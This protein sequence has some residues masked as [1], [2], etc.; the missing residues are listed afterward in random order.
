LG[1]AAVREGKTS[2]G[3]R[4]EAAGWEASLVIHLVVEVGREAS[5]VIPLVV[6]AGREV[7]AAL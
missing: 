7:L 5:L 2:R 6:E 4:G 1:T 3:S